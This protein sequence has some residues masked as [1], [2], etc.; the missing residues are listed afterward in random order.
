[1]TL[2]KAIAVLFLL[3]A[4]IYGYA[5]FTYHLLPFERNM[6]FL[7]NTFPKALSVLAII[8]SLIIIVTPKPAGDS[9]EPGD[10]D[11]K[12]LGRYNIMQASGMIIAMVLYALLLRPIG[13][14]PATIGFLVGTGWILGERKLHYMIAIAAIG[15]VSIWYLVQETLGIYLKPLPWFM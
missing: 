4:L 8:L 7:P 11:I 10:M 1:M 2:D 15:T 12:K 14:I 13:F 6:S 9:D 3:I 5:S